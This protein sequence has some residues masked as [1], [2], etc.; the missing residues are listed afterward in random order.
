MISFQRVKTPTAAAAFFIDHLAEAD[1][2]LQMLGQRTVTYVNNRMQQEHSR[3]DHLAHRIPMLFFLV[4]TRQGAVIDRLEQQM[5]SLM[6]QQLSQAR[7]RLELLQGR[8][9]P[10]ITQKL[11]T[12][13]HRLEQYNLR[14]KAVDPQIIL[15]RGYSLTTLHGKAIRDASMIKDGDTIETRF[16]KGSVTSIVQSQQQNH[17]A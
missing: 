2:H 6:R 4:K 1:N 13:K 16:A 14:L 11:N 3:L 17:H 10:A 12:E 9:L 7:Y 5:L 15:Q 8:T